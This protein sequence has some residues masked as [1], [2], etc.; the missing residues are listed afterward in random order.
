MSSSGCLALAVRLSRGCRFRAGSRA[1]R[2]A[3]MPAGAAKGRVRRPRIFDRYRARSAVESDNGLGTNAF[4]DLA[5]VGC[6]CFGGRG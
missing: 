3:G 5:A 4:S 1:H 2:Q 6:G